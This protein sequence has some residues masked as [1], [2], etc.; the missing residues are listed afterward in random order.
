MGT[1][2]ANHPVPRK[3]AIYYYELT[4]LNPGESRL[5]A[6]GFAPKAHNH[7]KK[8]GWEGNSYGY[9]ADDGKKFHNSCTGEKYAEEWGR[10]PGAVVGAAIHMRRREI[11]FT[12]GWEG[13]WG[14][15]PRE[16]VQVCAV[17]KLCMVLCRYTLRAVC[18]AYAVCTVY[19]VYVVFA[20]HA[21]CTV[22]AV[23]AAYAV[24]TMCAVCTVH[25]MYA[26]YAMY[27]VCAE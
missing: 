7:K 20:T 19:A 9:H 24:Y 1:I 23:C 10:E 21:V 12:C 25:A 17:H 13:G 5:I 11:F 18:A 22:C 26:V 4:V 2:R 15:L 27:A 16:G 14:V 6:I 3:R 8:P